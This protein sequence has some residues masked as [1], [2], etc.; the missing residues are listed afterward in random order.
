MIKMKRARPC[1]HTRLIKTKKG[2]RTIVVNKG[3]K[4]KRN[5]GS[6]S[7]I[8]KM[9]QANQDKINANKDKI[10]NIKKEIGD[11]LE[12]YY[13]IPEKPKLKPVNPR[14][15]EHEA[16]ERLKNPEAFRPLVKNTY[17]ALR[18]RNEREGNIRYGIPL[19]E[20]KRP[21]TPTEVVDRSGYNYDKIDLEI[22]N[23]KKKL[24][25][26][27]KGKPIN[28]IAYLSAASKKLEPLDVTAYNKQVRD[29]I[30][31]PN[32]KK[33]IDELENYIS[34]AKPLVKEAHKRSEEKRAK[35]LQAQIDFENARK[36]KQLE[37]AKK[38]GKKYKRKNR[39]NS[40]WR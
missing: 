27:L 18:E 15:I 21:P 10:N 17:E 13:V 30:K 37:Y 9:M 16:R 2:R 23:R 11:D 28:E 14:T 5:N 1:K 7:S 39:R 12:E 19:S 3:I 36:A 35:E 33:K 26:D 31:N 29:F 40:E 24:L 20:L 8:I 32:V 4:R 6:K 34:K 25:Q 38:Y 22:F